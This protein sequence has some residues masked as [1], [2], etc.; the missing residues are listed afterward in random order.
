MKRCHIRE[1]FRNEHP[2]ALIRLLIA[3][4][5]AD[6][7][8]MKTRQTI[9]AEFQIFV[10]YAPRCDF[11]LSIKDG[12]M[13]GAGNRLAKG[14]ECGLRLAEHSIHGSSAVARKERSGFDLL[15]RLIDPP[16]R[17]EKAPKWLVRLDS[18]VSLRRKAEPGLPQTPLGSRQKTV[19][20]H[21]PA[22]RRV[23][24]RN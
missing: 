19:S 7:I 5:P 10:Q 23:S 3:I 20:S 16:L 21:A 15:I 17:G 12:V 4:G 8:D 2:S 11:G 22:R 24:Q 13:C 18:L 14:R 6:D 1:M 9:A